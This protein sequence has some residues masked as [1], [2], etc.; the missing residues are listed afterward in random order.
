MRQYSG[1]QI[2]VRCLVA[3]RP[4]DRFTV[5]G[6]AATFL[7]IVAAGLL[8]RTVLAAA[9]LLLFLILAGIAYVVS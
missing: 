1:L 6:L 3:V 8:V 9:A 7:K 5:T 2:P 4:A